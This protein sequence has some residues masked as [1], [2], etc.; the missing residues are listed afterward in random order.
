[1]L[2]ELVIRRLGVHL[3]LLGERRFPTWHEFGE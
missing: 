3:V 2:A 1:M